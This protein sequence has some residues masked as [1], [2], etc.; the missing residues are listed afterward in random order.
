MAAFFAMG[1]Y[2]L[3]VW[4]CYVLALAVMA[5]LLV[6]SLLRARAAETELETVRQNRLD[7]PRRDKEVSA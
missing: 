1:G 3:F 2:A 6:N 7:R 4:P 5:G